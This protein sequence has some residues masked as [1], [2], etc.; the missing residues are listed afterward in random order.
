MSMMV[1]PWTVEDHD[2]FVGLGEKIGRPA[3]ANRLAELY[4]SG[5][6]GSARRVSPPLLA[7]A[8]DYE[9]FE[10]A[11]KARVE[12]PI[13]KW[14]FA[15]ENFR[16]AWATFQKYRRKPQNEKIAQPIA[17]IQFLRSVVQCAGW[18][19]MSMQVPKRRVGATA[20]K[21]RSA[22]THLDALSKL[23]REGVRLSDSSQQG[24]LETLL[25]GLRRELQARSRKVYEGPRM[26]GTHA[27]EF[28]A[29]NLVIDFGLRSP[30]IVQDI[31][32]MVGLSRERTTCERYVRAA[33][34]RWQS[35]LADALKAH[36]KSADN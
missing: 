19:F 12:H 25:Q 15:N 26:T 23:F 5:P 22:M 6:L 2:S 28:L 33:A 3:A 16:A 27:L 32:N 35:A 24:Q 11:W 21:R 18:C 20:P 31:A 34:E 13:Y 4:L 9:T 17:D 8:S 14:L 1:G 36:Q 7:S 10:D 30:A 29:M